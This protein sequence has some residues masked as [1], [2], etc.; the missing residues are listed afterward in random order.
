MWKDKKITFNLILFA[1]FGMLACQ[2][3]YFFMC[4]VFQSG[5]GDSTSVYF[6][7]YN[8]VDMSVPCQMEDSGQKHS[9]EGKTGLPSSA[10]KRYI[11]SIGHCLIFYQ[12]IMGELY[13]IISES[14]FMQS[15]NSYTSLQGRVNR[16]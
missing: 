4:V 1:A 6:H 8:H 7:G 9:L 10:K 16:L 12:R 15:H 2:L 5:N 14:K 3:T 11:K 13:T